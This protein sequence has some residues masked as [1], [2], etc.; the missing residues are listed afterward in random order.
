VKE[1]DKIAQ[2]D[3]V[4]QPAD[5]AVREGQP[6][7]KEERIGHEEHQQE[8]PGKHEDDTQAGLAFEKPL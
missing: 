5:H 7:P 6:D 2:P 8:G 1:V 3:E 4:A